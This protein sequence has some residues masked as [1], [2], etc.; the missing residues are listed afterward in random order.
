MVR[1]RHDKGRRL[2]KKAL[3]IG[4]VRLIHVDT[5]ELLHCGSTVLDEGGGNLLSPFFS[6][7]FF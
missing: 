4:S 5:T 1:S 3:P 2:S 7:P 6:D